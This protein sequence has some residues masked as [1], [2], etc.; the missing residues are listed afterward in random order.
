MRSIV[1]FGF[2]ILV[3][4]CQNKVTQE[5]IALLNGYWEIE[6]VLKI[7]NE[8][9]GKK[10]YFVKWVGH[11]DSHNSWVSADKFKRAPSK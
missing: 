10:K 5:D 7:K 4:G 9:K 1:A 6:K 11:D 8:P 3:S 2:F